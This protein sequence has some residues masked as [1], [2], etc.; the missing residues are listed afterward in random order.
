MMNCATCGAQVTAGQVCAQCGTPA[1]RAEQ[2]P[3]PWADPGA[4]PGQAS[5]AP[6]PIPGMQAPPPLPGAAGNYGPPGDF[7]PPGG[8]G[9]PVAPASDFG[10]G[11]PHNSYAAFSAPQIPTPAGLSLPGAVKEV[12]S[13]YATFQGR[14]TRSEYWWWALTVWLALGVPWIAAALITGATHIHL[15]AS[16]IAGLLGLYTLIVVLG[17]V[18]PSLAVAMR[19]MHDIGQSGALFLIN[20]VPTIGAIVFLVLCGLPS[21]PFANEYGLAPAPRQPAGQL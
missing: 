14:A 4:A 3:A 13:K 1:P 2:G 12:F 20:L 18:V 15:E 9:P 16:P 6:G 8:Y 17:A 7:G 10:Y 19:R 5:G 11:T 21:K